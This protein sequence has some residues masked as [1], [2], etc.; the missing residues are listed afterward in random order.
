MKGSDALKFEC[1]HCKQHLEATS[2][3][4]D[5]ELVCP[6]C[7]RAL[8][9]PSQVAPPAT[10]GSPQPS[11]SRTCDGEPTSPTD[12]TKPLLKLLTFVLL[13]PF[14]AIYYAW[15]WPIRQGIAIAKTNGL[16]PHW[17]WLGFHPAT[18]W[19]VYIY[20]RCGVKRTL[21]VTAGILA[22]LC[23]VANLP[24]VR[25]WA[26]AQEAERKREEAERKR[27]QAELNRFAEPFAQ[28]LASDTVS[29]RP[30]V[31][32]RVRLSQVLGDRKLICALYD[33]STQEL[34]FDDG[35]VQP[36][37]FSFSARA[38][39]M[40]D[41]NFLVVQFHEQSQTRVGVF[42][43]AS[44]TLLRAQT[45][46]WTPKT[47][48]RS[49]WVIPGPG[50]GVVYVDKKT[51]FGGVNYHY[52]TKYRY[53]KNEVTAFV[54][55]A[56]IVRA[57]KTGGFDN[58]S[59]GRT[60]CQ[61]LARVR[62]NAR[63]IGLSFLS[64]NKPCM[65]RLGGFQEELGKHRGMELLT[66][67][68]CNGSMDMAFQV[69]GQLLERYPELDAVFAANDSIAL[70]A[71]AALKSSGRLEHVTVVSVDGSPEGI[72]AMQA[73]ELHMSVAIGNNGD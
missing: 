30:V 51:L 20:L 49:E 43:I 40:E 41:A 24:P 53:P 64:S 26:E 66:I 54:A 35:S 42:D 71:I 3:M 31:S 68:E 7:Q 39:K 13:L 50:S 10:P 52:D 6:A 59:A 72:K 70:G 45:V 17:M 55:T 34:S 2:E 65:D 60:A 61:A 67:Q 58:V 15:I 46:P 18:A 38:R 14:W 27:E 1:P 73:G 11:T 21:A 56:I 44:R 4:A 25:R 37:L 48:R 29:R 28:V 23:F 32:G 63:A 47:T 8:T 19:A 57:G 69:M 5:L 62:P 12:A 22:L 16:S 9:I 36:R 33:P